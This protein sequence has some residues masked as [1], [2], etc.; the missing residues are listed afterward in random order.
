M[1]NVYCIEIRDRAQAEA[2][3]K[4][5]GCDSFGIN[6]MAYKVVFR[7]LKVKSVTPTQAN[8]VKQEML[9][10]GGEAA[11]T[12]GT[13]N[14]SVDKTDMLLMGTES[15]YKKLCEKLK[16]QPFKLNALA[17]AIER[18]INSLNAKEVYKIECRGKTLEFGKRTLIMGILNVTPDSFSD[19]GKFNS[20]DAALK[21]AE[22]MIEEGADIIDVGGE[23]T[24]PGYKSVDVEEELKRVIP[25]IK[26]LAMRFDV[27]ISVDTS[28]AEVAKEALEA[29]AHI[30]NDVWA[31]LASEQMLDTIAAYDAAVVLMHNKRDNEYK[32][33]MAEIV[34]YLFDAVNRA[35][36]AGI[37]REKII[38]DPGIG[39]GKNVEQ[40]LE[41]MRRLGELKSIGCPI[42]LGTSRKSVI[43]KTLDLPVDER[44]E[45]TAATIAYGIAKGVDIVRV[46]DV[47]HMKR[48]CRMTDAIVRGE[49]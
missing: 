32:D 47:E 46:H 4:K 30:V 42:L 11:V 19:G 39:F 16:L 34:E 36:S 6:H 21:H 28:K 7:V 24:R 3:L 17:D 37:A 26:E 22:Q 9:S 15:Q 43:G 48:V 13:V 12:R 27:V 2:E 23:S 10:L 45:G 33:M 38:I 8:I 49:T 18:V 29:G 44:K 1:N 41:V 35:V 31:G 14:H 25:V 5:I 20:I 40:N